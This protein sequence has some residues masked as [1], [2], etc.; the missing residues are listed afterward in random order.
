MDG[1]HLFFKGIM[2]YGAFLVVLLS[3]TSLCAQAQDRARP[4]EN[5]SMP[6]VALE[7]GEKAT[8]ARRVDPTYWEQHEGFT[9]YLF[10]DVS[11]I[12]NDAKGRPF[13]VLDPN[14]K[15][16]PGIACYFSKA[17]LSTL[18]SFSKGQRVFVSGVIKGR[19]VN[20]CKLMLP[21]YAKDVWPDLQIEL[22]YVTSLLNGSIQS[23]KELDQVMAYLE[24]FLARN[25]GKLSDSDLLKCAA[26][27]DHSAGW[28]ND[29]PV[30]KRRK[31]PEQYVGTGAVLRKGQQ[32]DEIV[33]EGCVDESPAQ[34]AG[35]R[36]DDVV[37][38]VDG[39]SVSGKELDEVVRA[40]RGK[41]GTYVTFTIQRN[42]G[43]PERVRVERVLIR[44][45]ATLSP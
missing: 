39:V 43:P 33:I 37:I 21:V 40:V 23:Q 18:Q 13:V 14:G 1:P 15:T 8:S 5:S 6:T 45:G 41:V 42:G 44:V 20:D 22:K 27:M 24:E 28:F 10:G 31:S 34:K 11:E 12:G 25:K 35:L 2:K 30:L 7:N 36:K 3:G 26:A 4:D 29:R 32:S 19:E 17:D 16:V 9:G 38:A